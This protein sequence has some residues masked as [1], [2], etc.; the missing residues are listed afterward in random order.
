MTAP[1]PAQQN[2]LALMQALD[3]TSDELLLNRTGQHSARQAARIAQ[4]TQGRPVTAFQIVVV[5]I[6][7]AIAGFLFSLRRPYLLHTLGP[8]AVIAGIVAAF[9]IFLFILFVFSRARK[10]GQA[11]RGRWPVRRAIGRAQVQV[12]GS[13]NQPGGLLPAGVVRVGRARFAVPDAV[14]RNF[15]PGRPYALY[16]VGNRR[17]G[18][19]VS[20]E[21]LEDGRQP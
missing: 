14:L 15:T 13:G 18:L 5:F 9:V 21:A 3:F 7:M 10:R 11:R 20:A 8:G 19:L 16:F 12:S 1:T 6:G 17:G 4:Q 2:T